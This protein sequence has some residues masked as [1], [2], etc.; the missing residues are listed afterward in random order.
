MRPTCERPTINRR[1]NSSQV[2]VAFANARCKRSR[3][4][5][6]RFISKMGGRPKGT[7]QDGR[8][9]G[10]VMETARAAGVSGKLANVLPRAPRRSSS[11]DSAASVQTIIIAIL[12]HQ[13]VEG[14]SLRSRRLEPQFETEGV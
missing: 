14:R 5:S 12:L 3:R 2:P 13:F 9:I 1:S 11:P 6:G 7:L 4:P 8:R 10:I